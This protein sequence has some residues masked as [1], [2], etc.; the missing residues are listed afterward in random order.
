MSYLNCI[1]AKLS[2]FLDESLTAP[3]NHK[4]D[5]RNLCSK[6][7]GRRPSHNQPGEGDILALLLCPLQNPRREGLVL[8]SRL[9][10]Q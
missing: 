8:L 3:G 6:H 7:R 9:P 4:I 5:P 10:V 2:A 1:D